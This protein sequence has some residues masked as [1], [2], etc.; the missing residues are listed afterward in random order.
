MAV[1]T[2]GGREVVAE[3]LYQQTLFL[4]VGVGSPTWDD[5]LVPPTGMVTDLVD[6]VGVTRCREQAFVEPDENG[7]IAMSDG[8]KF[9]R[10]VTPTRY[11]YLFFKLDLPDA[12]PFTL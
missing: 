5:A 11:L 12:Q 3:L 6:K 7:D 2:V 4:A 9:I 10:S 1:F 8:G